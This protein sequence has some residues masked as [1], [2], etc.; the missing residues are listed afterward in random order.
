MRN[1]VKEIGQK[2]QNNPMQERISIA[3]LISEQARKVGNYLVV[4]GGSAV[5]FYTAASYMTKD[6][7]FVAKDGHRIA[8]IMRELGFTCQ[9]GNYWTHPD[10]AVVV[11]FPTAS[12]DDVLEG[13][14]ERVL[15]VETDYGTANV[16]GIEDIIIDRLCGREFWYDKNTLPEQLV[17]SH[18]DEID[19][20]YLWKQARY[21]LIDK[22]LEECLQRV[23]KYK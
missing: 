23:E 6:L 9:I 5:E 7:D 16:I 18:Y 19:F 8:E 11:E 2:F 21:Q 1:L 20:D 10:T 17:L 22:T 14:P 3:A 12:A 4:V 15:Q 13:D